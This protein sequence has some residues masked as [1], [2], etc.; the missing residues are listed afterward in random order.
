MA[1]TPEPTSSPLSRRSEVL[2]RATAPEV[3]RRTKGITE[4]FYPRLFDQH[5]ELLRLFNHGDQASGEQ[6]QALVA[7]LTAYGMQL[8][9]PDAP[10]FHHVLQRIAHRHIS[11]GIRPEQYIAV[12]Q[13]L[14]AALREELGDV[15][16]LEAADAWA[17]LHVLS[18]PLAF[19]L[20]QDQ[21]LHCK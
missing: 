20:S 8:I 4:R 21:T 19:I 15:V 6:G 7:S 10:S 14:I 12:G 5:P 11:L 17:E 16:T 9:D 1:I 18:L 3:S 2:V 13:H